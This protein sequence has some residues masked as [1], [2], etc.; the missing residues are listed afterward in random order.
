MIVES[1]VISEDRGFSLETGHKKNTLSLESRMNLCG[2][3]YLFPFRDYLSGLFYRYRRLLG[4]EVDK[5][6]N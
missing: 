6:R 1:M 5:H 3:I 4:E 2:T